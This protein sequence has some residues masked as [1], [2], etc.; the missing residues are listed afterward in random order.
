MCLWGIKPSAVWGCR[1]RK[2]GDNDSVVEW[3]NIAHVCWNR[4]VKDLLIFGI[5]WYA[6]E[7]RI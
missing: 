5:V 4:L 2:T 7:I 6:I 3:F 1:L